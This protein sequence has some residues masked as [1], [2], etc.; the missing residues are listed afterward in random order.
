M[1]IYI[2]DK[3]F[4]TIK[5]VDVFESFMWTERYTGFGNVEIY[6]LV[7]L[8]LLSYAELG[9]YIT[10]RDSNSIMIIENIQLTS[11]VEEGPRM[12]ISGRS[13]EAILER[14]IIW[15]A[16][17]LSGSFQ[18]AIKT[19][20]NNNIIN[21]S[22]TYRRINN[23]IFK[24]S[25]DTRITSLTIEDDYEG[26]N[27][28]EVITN[29]CM[30]RELGYRITLNESNQFVFELYYGEDRSYE[31]TANPYIVFSP[32]FE[33]LV[34]SNYLQSTSVWKNVAFVIGNDANDNQQVVKV[35]NTI[36]DLSRRELYVNA[37]D[38][39]SKYDNDT[40][41]PTSIFLAALTNRGRV[42]LIKPENRLTTLVEAQIDTMQEGFK[43]GKD[44]NKGDIV[45]VVDEFGIQNRVRVS[46]FFI[47]QDANG[48]NTYPTF[49]A[50]NYQ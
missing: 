36:T 27:L 7:D 39:K 45:Q 30:E 47:S 44:F 23:F 21:P 38:V 34:D 16:T 31:Q 33:N 26:D 1:D 24:E 10:L 20:L 18:N 49:S 2:L 4:N 14:R 8:D 15:P 25:T 6:T 13:L 41:V 29:L 5:I 22:D 17:V 46:E 3:E 28:Y 32:H 43:Y 19:L 50:V 12:I 37:S 48:Y 9:N 42:E 40:P 35:N 11:Q